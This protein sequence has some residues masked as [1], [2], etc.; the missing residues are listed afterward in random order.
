MPREDPTA[1]LQQVLGLAKAAQSP[2][3]QWNEA[4]SVMHARAD[5]FR[6]AKIDAI[7]EL[8]EEHLELSTR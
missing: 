1:I 7:V 5:E 3:I 6:R 2:L 8:L 4:A